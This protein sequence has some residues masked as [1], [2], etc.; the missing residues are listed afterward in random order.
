M[1]ALE[2]ALRS[3]EEAGRKG[4]IPS[5]YLAREVLLAL[6]RWIR[7]HGA[8]PADP[9]VGRAREAGRALGGG[10]TQAVAAELSMACAEFAQSVDPRYLDLPDYDLDYTLEARARLEDRLVAARELGSRPADRE[11]E[12]VGMADQVLAAHLRRKGI[13]S[14]AIPGC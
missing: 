6:G 12:I 7:E 4:W 5:H 9:W 11:A 3:L 2:T 1:N 10:W 14:D 8:A 13:Q